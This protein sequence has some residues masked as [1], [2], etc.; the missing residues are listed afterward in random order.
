MA[1]I[2][3]VT[4]E[5]ND[6]SETFDFKAE[7]VENTTSNGLVTDSIISGLREVIGGKLVLEVEEFVL[8][9]IIKDMDADQYPNSGTYSDDDLGFERELQRAAKTW[10]WDSSDG[11]DVL[12]WGPR[13][14]IEGVITQ[15]DT[16]E[17]A[18]DSELGAGSYALTVEFTYLD[19]FI[20]G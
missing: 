16:E 10:G 14:A 7:R 1:T 3:G 12:Y 20:G 15:V 11:F 8:E 18:T 13:S 9:G 17:N 5:R 6:G 19:A 2:D 4:L